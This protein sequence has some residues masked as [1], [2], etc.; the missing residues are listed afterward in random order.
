MINDNQDRFDRMI[1]WPN[2]VWCVIGGKK[3]SNIDLDCLPRF[4]FFFFTFYFC[5]FSQFCFCFIVASI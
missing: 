4:R 2:Y 3:P 5:Y 1:E